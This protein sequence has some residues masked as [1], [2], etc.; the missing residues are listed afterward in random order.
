[1]ASCTAV[2]A[3]ALIESVSAAS[4]AELLDEVAE[5]DQLEGALGQRVLVQRLRHQ[6]MHLGGFIDERLHLQLRL[7]AQ[8]RDDVSMESLAQ[9]VRVPRRHAPVAN[10][11]QHLASTIIQRHRSD[12]GHPEV[13]HDRLPGRLFHG[14][15]DTVASHGEPPTIEKAFK[16]AV[17]ETQVGLVDRL[18]RLAVDDEAYVVFAVVHEQ[19]HDDGTLTY[20]QEA[21]VG[22]ELLTGTL[23][24]DCPTHDL[25]VAIK[26]RFAVLRDTHTADDVR[27]TITRTL[28]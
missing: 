28:Q 18:L 26:S 6:R 3:S 11:V 10:G 22:L 16:L 19:K 7:L 17:R 20:T 21:K 5:V 12:V 23:N 15:R 2:V 8:Q 9:R 24:T 25:V 13:P 4:G 14:H 1:M 27:R